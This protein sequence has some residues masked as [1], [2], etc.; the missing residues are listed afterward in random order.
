MET[1]FVIKTSNSLALS[2]VGDCFLYVCCVNTKNP[3]ASDLRNVNNAKGLQATSKNSTFEPILILSLEL[4]RDLCFFLKSFYFFFNRIARYTQSKES[5][6]L[7]KKIAIKRAKSNA[8][9]LAIPSVSNFDEVNI[10]KSPA[11]HFLEIAFKK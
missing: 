9:A 10:R 3:L 8:K 1:Y 7:P 4:L 6:N 5:R 2:W 11:K